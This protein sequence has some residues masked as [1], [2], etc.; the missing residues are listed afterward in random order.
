[1]GDAA[2]SGGSGGLIRLKAEKVFCSKYEKTVD[3]D[4]V[5]SNEVNNAP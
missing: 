2:C 3:R 1:M 5:S 4:Y